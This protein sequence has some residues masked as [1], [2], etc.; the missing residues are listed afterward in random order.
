[1][2]RENV[3][4]MKLEVPP[5]DTMLTLWD[6]TTRRIQWRRTSIDVDLSGTASASTTTSLIFPETQPNQMQSCSFPIWEESR[7]SPPWTRS[8]PLLAPD[9]MQPHTT[10]PKTTKNM[11][12]KTKPQRKSSKATK[13][14]QPLLQIA[15][16]NDKPKYVKGQT[17][18]IAEQ[19][20]KAG[21]Y[22]VELH[23]YYIQI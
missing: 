17:M 22:C 8:T 7:P 15:M 12:S 5:D 13:G 1:M 2:V 20:C 11:C 6:A 19:L 3:K 16:M 9:Q 23:N 10:P 14:K 18:L 21:Q 4:N